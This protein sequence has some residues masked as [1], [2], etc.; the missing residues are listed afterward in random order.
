MRAK[1]DERAAVVTSTAPLRISIRNS[2]RLIPP[3][4]LFNHLLSA[5]I[6]PHPCDAR[7]RRRAWGSCFQCW[8][9]Q[10][11]HDD[12]RDFKQRFLFLLFKS[13]PFFPLGLSEY[14]IKIFFLADLRLVMQ[15]G[16][17]TSLVWRFYATLFWVCRCVGKLVCVCVG[18]CVACRAVSQHESW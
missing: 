1:L 15:Q 16:C 18:H 11:Q 5:P 3:S 8:V 9:C 7:V 17:G 4:R 12:F 13:F 2:P 14:K 6:V 10:L